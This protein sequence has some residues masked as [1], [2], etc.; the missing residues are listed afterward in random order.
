MKIAIFPGSFKPPH[1]GHFDLIEKMLLDNKFDKIILFISFTPRPLDPSLYEPSSLHTEDLYKILLNYDQSIQS[2]LTKKEYLQIYKKLIK[3]NKIPYVNAEQSI[4]IWKIYRDY[5][6][7]KY[8][9]KKI[10]ELD[11]K[12]SYAPSP[13]LSTAT[14]VK[15]LVNK[16][17]IKQTNIHL[18]KSYK[19][20]KN[21]RFDIVKKDY[22]K[23]KVN[24][25]KSKD[26][27]IHSK[28][29]RKAILDKD[30]K[31]IKEYL[32]KELSNYQINK[33]IKILFNNSNI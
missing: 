21:Q 4:L 19:N 26:P 5:L 28:I 1:K 11:L 15:K 12:I 17:Q 23:V 27:N 6:L 18:L 31:I 2:V 14:L 29:F 9:D 20:R 8:K 32:P 10:P 30:K 24:I 33:I 13:I 3:E 25:I 7:N 16:E 22:P